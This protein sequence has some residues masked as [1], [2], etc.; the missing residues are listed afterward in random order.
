MVSTDGELTDTAGKCRTVTTTVVNCKVSHRSQSSKV[1][2]LLT[3]P[4]IVSLTFV[5]RCDSNGLV[6]LLI[7]ICSVDS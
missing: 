5:N 3:A 6:E 4:S 1:V 2:T 7:S